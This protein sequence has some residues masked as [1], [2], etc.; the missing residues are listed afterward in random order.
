[1]GKITL[2][3]GTVMAMATFSKE[4]CDDI[5]GIAMHYGFLPDTHIMLPVAESGGV[6]LEWFKN[7]C[8]KDASF[9]DIDT[10]AEKRRGNNLLFLPYVVGT[11]SPE[12]DSRATGVFWG[13][14][15]E[16]DAYDMALAVME[17]VGFLLKK[18][19]LY[20]K[21]NGSD[22]N[23]II[24]TGGGSKSALWCQL[25]ADITNIPIMVP[26][27]KEAACLG[28]AI[29][30]AVSDGA[31]ES[32]E[33]AAKS[34]EFEKVYTPNEDKKLSEKFEKFNKLYEFACELGGNKNE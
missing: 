34:I 7:S 24:A 23:A 27:E 4:P 16:H 19:L 33:E 22:A 25:Q 8:L 5:R 21:K 9:K 12:F 32:Y 6:S 2:S 15:G 28:A 20:I 13:L 3:T 17:G 11:N 26:K 14:R 1:M 10:E 31:I 29:I 18:N 30:A